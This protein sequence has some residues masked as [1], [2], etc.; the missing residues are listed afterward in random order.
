MIFKCGNVTDRRIGIEFRKGI[1]RRYKKID[2][3]ID[4]YVIEILVF[5]LFVGDDNWLGQA[6]LGQVDQSHLA[7][8]VP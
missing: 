6:V 3:W 1:C 4:R 8:A 7:L 5:F 2:R